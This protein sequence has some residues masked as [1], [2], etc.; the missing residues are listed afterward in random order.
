MAGAAP[1]ARRVLAVKPWTTSLVK[2]CTNGA[3]W[4]SRSREVAAVKPGSSI[5]RMVI[6]LPAGA[7]EHGPGCAR[8]RDFPTLALS[9]SGNTGEI[10]VQ[11]AASDTPSHVGRLSGQTRERSI[12]GVS[13]MNE[14]SA[15]AVVGCYLYVGCTGRR[16]QP[17][18]RT[19][20]PSGKPG[21]SQGVKPPRHPVVV[22]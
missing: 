13:G 5:G 11:R 3:R 15:H 14:H 4:R 2:Q 7:Q 20:T 1:R 18:R 22:I 6:L 8:D 12:T 19:S 10:S 16:E 21:L 17:G 9:R